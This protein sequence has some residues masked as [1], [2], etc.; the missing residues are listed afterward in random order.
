[1]INIKNHKVNIKG[2][3]ENDYYRIMGFNYNTCLALTYIIYDGNIHIP[4]L[5]IEECGLV[6]AVSIPLRYT[7][8]FAC[9]AIV[10]SLKLA[11]FPKTVQ[12]I[13]K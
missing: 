9:R 7:P 10:K 4:C 13:H 1:M 3:I 6:E 5:I 8:L 12:K 11:M 2:K